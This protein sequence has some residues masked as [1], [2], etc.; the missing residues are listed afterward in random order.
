MCPRSMLILINRK[1]L[2]DT[3]NEPQMTGHIIADISTA[4]FR[5]CVSS[6][7]IC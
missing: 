5:K 6:S 7:R 4:H 1:D 3:H 2:A